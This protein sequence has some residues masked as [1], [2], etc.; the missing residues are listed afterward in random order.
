MGEEEGRIGCKK[1]KERGKGKRRGE[2]KIRRKVNEGE[3]ST[4]LFYI[5]TWH[6]SQESLYYIM[7]V[8][9]AGTWSGKYIEKVL[10]LMKHSN[11][12]STNVFFFL[13]LMAFCLN[14]KFSIP[15]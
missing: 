10:I 15:Y 12:K 7:F 11:K 4:S 3:R 14:T 6:Y 9:K 1:G 8:A 5:V 2:A 13:V